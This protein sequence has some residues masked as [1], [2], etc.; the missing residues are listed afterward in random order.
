[1]LS[2]N[3]RLGFKF[4]LVFKSILLLFSRGYVIMYINTTP[5]PNNLLLLFIF[6]L[7]KQNVLVG[8][9]FVLYK[10]RRNLGNEELSDKFPPAELLM[11]K[12]LIR[13]L[14]VGTG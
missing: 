12:R 14:K 5:L 11:R 13:Q 9:K 8:C 7:Q 10:A 4:R 3:P 6:H 1:M 2:P